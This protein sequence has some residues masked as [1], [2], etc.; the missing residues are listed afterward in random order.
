MTFKPYTMRSVRGIAPNGF[1]AVS[2]FSGCGGSCLGLKLAGF[3]VV[4]ANEFIDSAAAAYLA[5][6]QGTI[7]DRRDIREV[8]PEE[9]LAAIGMEKSQLDLFEGS[10]PCS[11]FSQAG[12]REKGW[13]QVKQYSDSTSQRTDDL[14]H[15]YIR[16]LNGLMPRM[17]VAE[18]V[19][20]LANGKA[21]GMFNEFLRAFKDAGYN[22]KASIVGAHWLGV[23]QR[24]E[25]LFFIGAREDL[26]VQ[27]TFPTP[28]GPAPTLGQAF[29]GLKEPGEFLPLRPDHKIRAVYDNARRGE[30]LDK[31]LSRETGKKEAKYFTHMR[32]SFNEPCGTVTACSSTVYH[33]D[34]PRTLGLNELRRVC[35]F[36]DDFK[37]GGSFSQNWER[38]GRSVPPLMMA[39]I[40]KEIGKTLTEVAHV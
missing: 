35:G 18:N 14:F 30:H 16:L 21:K 9:I 1:K 7:L 22:V 32:A 37:L 6:H 29:E 11:S 3:R 31:T 38:L 25:R 28:F 4:W 40:A 12:R 13:G 24:R 26:A 5:N 23:P 8:Q 20:G 15:E 10:P 17:F 19:P 36:P 27:P 39:A 2:T 34:E 33:P